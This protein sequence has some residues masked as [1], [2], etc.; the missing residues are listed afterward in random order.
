MPRRTEISLCILLTLGFVFVINTQ[1]IPLCEL[2]NEVEN[3]DQERTIEE[4]KSRRV[5]ALCDAIYSA[6]DQ[7]EN[8]ELDTIPDFDVNHI[9]S[10]DDANQILRRFRR[11]RFSS[12]RSSSSSS[13]SRSSSSSSRSSSS[14][15]RFFGGSRS[16]SSSSSG[17]SRIF[18]SRSSSSSSGSRIFSRS[19]GTSSSSSTGSRGGIF[20][21]SS[22]SSSSSSGDKSHRVRQAIRSMIRKPATSGSGVPATSGGLSGTGGSK[23]SL[24]DKIRKITHGSGG[25]SGSTF[26]SSGSGG[27]RYGSG[28]SGGGFGM[29]GSGGS[30]GN[31][32]V[33]TGKKFLPYAVR[34]GK[35]YY[36]RRK[37]QKGMYAA[38]GAGA[39][40]YAGSRMNGHHGN[41]YPDNYYGYPPVVDN[42]PAEI[43][44][45]PPTVFYCIQEDLNTT[46]VNQTLDAEGF[47]VCNISGE[48]VTCPIEIECK[49]SEADT[50]CED[51]Q[52]APICCGGAIPD[53]YV[54]AYGGYGDDLYDAAESFNKILN[55]ITVISALLATICYT[56]WRREE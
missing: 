42:E 34:F 31:A 20:S 55:T 30:G 13:S 17:G 7:I 6:R 33:R 24:S 56:I 22:S 38:A 8:E 19:S 35:R 47:G 44:G 50:C 54:S 4:S 5:R 43:D 53:E 16:S 2:S 48:L 15:S 52:G 23:P 45:K 11:S 12:S 29:G 36:Q 9:N 46:L 37:Y 49:T 26:R 14:G 39:G 32:W 1:Y 21:R 3:D 25:G 51:E 28:I 40:Y 10:D 27:S 18:G 41:Y